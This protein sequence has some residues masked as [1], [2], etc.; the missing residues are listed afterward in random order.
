MKAPEPGA[1]LRRWLPP[2]LAVFS[3][4]IENND[5]R[6]MGPGVLQLDPRRVAGHYDDRVDAQHFGRQSHALA[7]ISR[8]KSN[9]P[10]PALRG[11]E[12]RQAVIGAAKLERPGQVQAFRLDQD[13][14]AG[15]LVKG[16]RRQKRRPDSLALNTP[17][18]RPDISKRDRKGGCSFGLSH[19][20]CRHWCCCHCWHCCRKHG[21][22][23][24]HSAPP[25]AAGGA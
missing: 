20:S 7:V 22:R 25:A 5:F 2:L 12:L 19:F 18:R 15:G 3:L 4:A 13:F 6:A 16:G 8:R 24:A 17:G 11:R 9:H 1:R 14:P 21:L 10:A 23:S